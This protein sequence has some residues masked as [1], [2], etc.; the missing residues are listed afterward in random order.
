[1]TYSIEKQ[2]LRQERLSRN[3]HVL[4]GE[5]DI[6]SYSR[7]YAEVEEVT[8]EFKDP[9]TVVCETLSS[10]GYRV[11]WD[12]AAKCFKAYYLSGTADAH[13]HLCGYPIFSSNGLIVMHDEDAG[14]HEYNTE[15]YIYTING[16]EAIAHI[17]SDTEYYQFWPCG[18]PGEYWPTGGVEDPILSVVQV[19]GALHST[20]CR[21]YLGADQRVYANTATDR[22]LIINLSGSI[23]V[24]YCIRVIYEAAPEA[25]TNMAPLWLRPMT[26]ETQCWV[27]GDFSVAFPGQGALMALTEDYISSKWWLGKYGEIEYPYGPSTA[28]TYD[29]ECLAGVDVGTVY[30]LATGRRK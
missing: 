30:Y 6:S 25:Q 5:I 15:L 20:S 26:S 8:S 9:P 7:T 2:I 19:L 1:M 18:G 4:S 17:V 11:K 12:S 21:L 29:Q 3:L 14:E 23:G 24:Q 27:L 28:N 16:R 10:K 22:D 13:D